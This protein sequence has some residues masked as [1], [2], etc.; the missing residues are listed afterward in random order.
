MMQPSAGSQASQQQP[1]Q[2]KTAGKK[3]LDKYKDGPLSD[4]I[5]AATQQ[6]I[7]HR[8]PAQFQQVANGAVPQT[9]AYNKD[10]YA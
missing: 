3:F 4:F 6:L 2:E 9:I 5:S 7:D 10:Y 1:Q 8:N